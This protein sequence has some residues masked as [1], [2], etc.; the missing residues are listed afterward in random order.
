MKKAFRARVPEKILGNVYEDSD[1]PGPP[2]AVFEIKENDNHYDVEWIDGSET[3]E[4]FGRF[5][6]FDSKCA[7]VYIT[8]SN[9]LTYLPYGFDIL[10]GLAAVTSGSGGQSASFEHVRFSGTRIPDDARID[11][12]SLSCRPSP[13]AGRH[14]YR[15]LRALAF[16][17]WEVVACA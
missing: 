10:E 16:F 14:N 12:E 17:D 8:E 4:A 1:S 2:T 13:V 11:A 5:A 6:V 15:I 7:R 3:P 9:Q